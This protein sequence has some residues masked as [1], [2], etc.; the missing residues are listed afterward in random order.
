MRENMKGHE[1]SRH[2]GE[3]QA[4]TAR[5]GA[6]DQVGVASPSCSTAFWCFVLFRGFC[7]CWVIFWTSFAIFFDPVGLENIFSSCDLGL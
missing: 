1:E 4:T 7:L 2:P 5:G 3:K 6:Q